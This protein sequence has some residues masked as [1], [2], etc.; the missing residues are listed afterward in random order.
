MRRHYALSE[1]GGN[2]LFLNNVRLVVD[3]SAISY[4]P[5]KSQLDARGEDEDAYEN[6]EHQREHGR[7]E[8]DEDHQVQS[9]AS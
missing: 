2:E 6:D 9:E 1:E 4:N 8:R 3:R 5:I 7:L